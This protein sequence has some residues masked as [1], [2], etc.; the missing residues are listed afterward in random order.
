MKN[1]ERNS[2]KAFW[3]D[4]G[5]KFIRGPF[6]V[7]GEIYDFKFIDKNGADYCTLEQ[8][9]FWDTDCDRVCY[10]YHNDI[11]NDRM[12]SNAT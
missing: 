3:D 9:N 8:M 7:D 11:K 12:L 2:I 4:Y 1:W 6:K 10:N 5:T